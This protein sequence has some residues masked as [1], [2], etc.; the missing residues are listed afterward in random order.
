MCMQSLQTQVHL[1]QLVISLDKMFLYKIKNNLHQQ[2]HILSEDFDEANTLFLSA[3]A[4]KTMK[5]DALHR[6]L[7]TSV[8]CDDLI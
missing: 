6:L 5:K 8:T 7:F 3:V 2:I 4:P 1:H